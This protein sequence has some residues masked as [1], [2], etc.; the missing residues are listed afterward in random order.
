M[1]NPAEIRKLAKQRLE[2]AAI[3]SEKKMFD[4]AFYL[5]GYSVELTFK[6]KICERL[7]IPNLFDETNSDAN[8]IRGIGEIRKTL[9]TH[10]LFTLLIFS[11]LKN[12]FDDEKTTNK[13]LAKVT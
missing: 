9:K 4:G 8:S 5:A 7:G 11:G 2:E 3:L 6:A 12:S 10:N 13:D 1:T